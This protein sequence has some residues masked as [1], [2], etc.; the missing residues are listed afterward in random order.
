LTGW[1][2]GAYA[3]ALALLV[4]SSADAQQQPKSVSPDAPKDGASVGKKPRLYVRVEGGDVE[5]L[6][7]RI[8][9]S[10]DEFKTIAYTFDQ[11]KDDD[12]WA[13]TV[14]DDQSPGAVYFVRQPLAGGS[15]VW[16]VASWDGLSWMDGANRFRIQVDD[17]P[18]ADVDGVRMNR[19]PGGSCVRISWEPVTT[20]RDGG[21]ERVARYHVYRYAAKGATHP[22]RPFEAGETAELAFEDCDA[23]FLDKPVLFYRVVAEDE[24]G[25][26]PGRKF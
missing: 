1:R 17:V 8:E 22:I 14:L 16:R 15:Y 13:A 21:P 19:A 7:F 9:L 12:G 4:A 10:R 2:R 20:D 24:A 25:N 3:G 6:R 18:P 5:K 26:I 11:L 23:S